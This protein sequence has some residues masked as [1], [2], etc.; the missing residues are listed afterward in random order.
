[1][2][3][4]NLLFLIT[5]VFIFSINTIL[6]NDCRSRGTLKEEFNNT[7]EVFSGKVIAQEYQEIT[8]A[9]DKDFG[10]QS[11]VVK[12]KVD[13]WWKGSGNGEVFLRT[14]TKRKGWTLRSGSD[15]FFKTGENYLVFAGVYK[16]WLETNNCT[17]TKELFRADEDLKELGAGFSANE[18]ILNCPAITIV[19]KK[20]ESSK[21]I[22][23]YL[24]RV[25]NA[26]NNRSLTYK[27]TYLI[28][29]EEAPIKAGQGTPTIT[30]G[31]VNLNL[32]ISVWVI[33]GGLPNGCKNMVG[34]SAVT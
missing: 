7:A 6:A 33:V 5:L 3:M 29:S 25:E 10:L 21:N 20:S 13:R 30:I 2:R 16:N 17:R 14:G 23:I 31:S 1:M 19:R 32:G 34:E 15:F 9:A 27:W 12:I 4:R 18:T 22:W 24:A 28:N 8:N 26:E 11:L